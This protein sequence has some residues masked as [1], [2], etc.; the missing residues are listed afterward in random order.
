MTAYLNK[1]NPMASAA[2]LDELKAFTADLGADVVCK[3]VETAVDENA[4]KWSYIRAILRNWSEA[5]VKNLQDLERHEADRLTAKSRN[6][7]PKVDEA[8]VAAGEKVQRSDMAWMKEYL[9]KQ[10][11]ETI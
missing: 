3:A 10:K 9:A 8:A 4:R 5:G 7:K 2:S 6:G 11:E 1:I